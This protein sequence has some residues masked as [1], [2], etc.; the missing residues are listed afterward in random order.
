MAW[1]FRHSIR[2]P[3]GCRLNLSRTGIGWSWGFPGLRLGADGKGRFTRTVSIP[4]MGICNR[5]VVRRTKEPI[6]K[7]ARESMSSTETSH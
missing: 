6:T 4:G 5:T 2:L 7:T 1:R 3:F